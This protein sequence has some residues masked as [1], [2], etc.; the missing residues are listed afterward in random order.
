V[1]SGWDTRIS[2]RDSNYGTRV[3]YIL[4]TQGILRWIKHGDIQASLKGS[5]H[6]PIYVDLYDKITLD[7]GET[8]SIREAMCQDYV[9]EGFPRIAAKFWDEFLAK[10]TSLDKFFGKGPKI[11]TVAPSGGSLPLTEIGPIPPI[12]DNSPQLSP[13]PSA[14][15]ELSDPARESLKRRM[16]TSTFGGAKARKKK[17]EQSK[18]STFFSKHSTTKTQHRSS[19][20]RTM[21]G[22]PDNL[23]AHLSSEE[24]GLAVKS[25]QVGDNG[26]AAWEQ[27]FARTQP[28]KCHIHNEPTIQ[29]TVTKTGPNKGKNF[30]ICSRYVFR[31]SIQPT[32]L[33]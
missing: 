25:L 7:S 15:T 5:D 29:L 27:L 9:T 14:T 16:S 8:M 19:S 17:V 10:Q 32:S 18:L 3:D 33:I 20:S 12:S 6:C 24:V 26:K 21:L 1:P 4:A 31:P 13:I 30:F 28:P 2:A 22:Q 11:L 23:P